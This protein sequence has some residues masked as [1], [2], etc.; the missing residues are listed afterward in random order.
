MPKIQQRNIYT[1]FIKRIS[2]GSTYLLG[3]HQFHLAFKGVS[4]T[5]SH[6]W[7]WAQ[8]CFSISWNN[9]PLVKWS[10]SLVIVAEQILFFN[11]FWYSKIIHRI[12]SYPTKF[13][14]LLIQERNFT[15]T[16]MWMEINCIF[17]FFYYYL[18]FVN[19]T[20]LNPSRD[21]KS[22]IFQS[23]VRSI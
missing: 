22:K 8:S 18:Q 12:S 9:E 19:F 13:K 5:F 21:P 4:V 16:L 11:D 7:N 14:T 23:T 17:L 20:A 2:G 3:N 6:S 1:L 10:K 15:S